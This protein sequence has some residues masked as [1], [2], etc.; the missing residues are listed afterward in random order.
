MVQSLR[1]LPRMGGVEDGEAV[2]DLR[3]GHRG[4]PG[5]AA[6]PVVPGQQRG[7]GAAFVDETGDVA[8]QLVDVVGMD[9]VWLGGQVVAAQVGG[10][11]PES[12]RR[13]RCDLPPPAIP[14]LGE[15]V[16]QHDQRP[17]TSLHVMQPL[18]ADLGITLTKFAAC[19]VLGGAHR[20]LPA[21]WVRE[22]ATISAAA[23][24]QG[25]HWVSRGVQPSSP[26]S[27]SFRIRR[28]PAHCHVPLAG[29]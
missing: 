10:D 11:D 19:L 18:V 13:Q 22:D 24:P 23:S 17:L 15:A 26:W 1:Q 29:A 12:R 27:G 2:H 5:D 21:G 16:Q 7:L 6:A 20:R 9:A 4:G 14:E 3:M 8:G 25:K 28:F